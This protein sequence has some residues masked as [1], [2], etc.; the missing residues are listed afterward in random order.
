MTNVQR[1]QI[2]TK[3]EDILLLE[4]LLESA[5]QAIL[6]RRFPKGDYP[7]DENGETYIEP[8]YLDLQFRLALSAYNKEGADFQTS[9][10]ENGVSRSW[11]SEGYPKE[12]LAEIVPLVSVAR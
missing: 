2:R 8:R 9:H 1:L 5:K 4:D 12:L 3:E 11:G 10:S 7:L 6:A